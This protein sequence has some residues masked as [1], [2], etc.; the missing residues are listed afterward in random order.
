MPN[1]AQKTG[2][3]MFVQ[4]GF[5][6]YGEAPVFSSST[7]KYDIFFRYPW[8]EDDQVEIK[9]PQ[10]YDLDNADAPGTV[11]DP[12]QIGLLE[13]KIG[14]NRPTA[15]LNYNRHFHFG[16]NGTVWFGA[17]MYKPLKGLFD[18]FNTADSHTITLKQK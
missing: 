5:F 6:E 14:V 8:S 12:K 4:P 2:K 15:L 18:A 16:G 10:S 7:R 13:I 17:E 9:Y 11:A 3:R 1:Y